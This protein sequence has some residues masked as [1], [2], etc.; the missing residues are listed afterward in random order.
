MASQT[1]DESTQ[2]LEKLGKTAIKEAENSQP[3]VLAAKTYQLEYE[4]QC[5]DADVPMYNRK[6]KDKDKHADFWNLV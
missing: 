2:S 3:R 5:G 6:W 1:I 4:G